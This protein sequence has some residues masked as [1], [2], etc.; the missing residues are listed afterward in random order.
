[1]SFWTINGRGLIISP[2]GSVLSVD[3]EAAPTGDLLPAL[4]VTYVDTAGELQVTP[5][6]D[7]VTS[8]SGVAPFSVHFDASGSR[9]VLSNNDSEE[10]AFH[11]LGYRLN[12]GEN[13]GTTWAYPEG[14]NLS[15]DEDFGPPIFGRVFTTTGT[16]TVR[17][18]CRDSAGAEAQISFTVVV[19]APASPTIIETSAGSWPTLVDG[20]HYGLRAGGNYTSFGPLDTALRANILFSKVGAGANPVIGV[21]RPDDTFAPDDDPVTFRP[22][23]N[24]RLQDIDVASIGT[25]AVGYQFCSAVR[26]N[27]SSGTGDLLGFVY[28]ADGTTANRRANIRRPRGL[29]IWKCSVGR[30]NDNYVYIMHA[31][32]WHMYGC[33]IAHSG[34]VGPTSSS[35]M[36]RAYGHESSFRYNRYRL[37]DWT[38]ITQIYTS[39]IG[40]QDISYAPVEYYTDQWGLTASNSPI[41]QVYAK[42]V[43][44]DCQWNASGG[45]YPNA[46]GTVGGSLGNT[47]KLVGMEN[48]RV[49]GNGPWGGSGVIQY[50]GNNCFV[51][52]VRYDM[53]SGASVPTAQLTPSP[54]SAAYDGP[55]VIESTNTRPVPTAFS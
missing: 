44:V 10:E 23:R 14:A 21:W 55:Y 17:L 1:M 15:E 20:T 42:F 43:Q 24:I 5:V 30:M 11:N 9:G 37:A 26:C 32:H 3:L 7:G 18:K 27:I 53:G 4:T 25:R 45:E 36:V 13:L 16:K 31:R 28:G 51:R 40:M 19:S 35:A 29:F 8:I 52:N 22:A 41:H 34:D 54:Y 47:S 2:T 38:G 33:D 49:F 12:Y 39:M 6:V 46:P 48:I 50:G